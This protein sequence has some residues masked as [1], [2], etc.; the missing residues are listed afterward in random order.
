MFSSLACVLFFA[1]HIFQA[2]DLQ[3]TVWIYPSTENFLP[4]RTASHVRYCQHFPLEWSHFQRYLARRYIF[5][6]L[7]PTGYKVMNNAD[8]LQYL[9]YFF[10]VCVCC[11]RCPKCNSGQMLNHLCTLILNHSNPRRKRRKKRY[12]E[13]VCEEKFFPPTNLASEGFGDHAS[14]TMA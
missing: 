11:F 12:E 5:T 1:S 9:F 10:C 13:P 8:V 7:S 4:P 2:P 14:E 3:S 6:L